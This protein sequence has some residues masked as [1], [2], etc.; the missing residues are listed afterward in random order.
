MRRLRRSLRFHL[1][2]GPTCAAL[3]NLPS[4]LPILL[5]HLGLLRGRLGLPGRDSSLRRI[6]PLAWRWRK[7]LATLRWPAQRRLGVDRAIVEADHGARD[8]LAPG[9]DHLGA[10]R[11]IFL[12]RA[13]RLELEHALALKSEPRHDVE[14]LRDPSGGQLLALEPVDVRAP[15]LEASRLDLH[16]VDHA[17]GIARDHAGELL[18]VS[19]GAD[20]GARELAHRGTDDVVRAGLAGRALRLN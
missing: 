15:I 16:Q 13:D 17:V 11:T 20:R 4:K 12:N 7:L 9:F 5:R 6:I 1:R 3:G 19:A 18:A 14:Q 2:L 8:L 10:Q